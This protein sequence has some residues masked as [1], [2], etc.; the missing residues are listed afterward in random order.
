MM[1]LTEQLEALFNN[2]P[3]DPEIRQIT[4]IFVPV[5]RRISSKLRYL[6]YHVLQTADHDWVS[7]TLNY[8]TQSH[9]EKT[10]IYAF[11]SPKN[12]SLSISA[13]DLEGLSVISIGIIDLLFQ[14]FTLNLGDSLIF[15]EDATNPE[16]GIE[17]S[18]QEFQQLLREYVDPIDPNIA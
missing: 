6:E 14:F 10:V 7:F 2:A 3:D 4:E 9:V 1:N 11:S 16:R 8:R 17:I 18:R 13:Q 15:F 5:L 12:V